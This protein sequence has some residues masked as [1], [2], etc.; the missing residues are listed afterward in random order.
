MAFQALEIDLD[1]GVQLHGDGVA[2][3]ARIDVESPWAVCDQ[4]I[5]RICAASCRMPSV[6]RKPAASS[7]SWPGVRM[8]TEID[9][10]C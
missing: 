5:S 3:L 8:V 1:T 4:R 10:S 9:L 2:E 6:N 7:K